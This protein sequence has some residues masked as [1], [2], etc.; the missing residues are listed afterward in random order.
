MIPFQTLQA[1]AIQAALDFANLWVPATDGGRSAIAG[2]AE[3]ERLFQPLALHRFQT[4]PDSDAIRPA[5]DQK[6]YRADQRELREWLEALTQWR[7][8]KTAERLRIH[9]QIAK[10]LG[11]TVRGNVLWRFV[12][13][14]VRSEVTPDLSGVQAGYSFGAA[15]LAD[16]AA[17]RWQGLHRCRL[18]S[19]RIYFWVQDRRPG[20]T[21]QFCTDLHATASRKARFARKNRKAK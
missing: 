12:D 4:I 13:G 10:R 15:M 21:R 8:L 20:P 9:Q 16:E 1:R 3:V 11:D 5:R 18:P 19:C 2:A 17:E 6:G 14:M 7:R